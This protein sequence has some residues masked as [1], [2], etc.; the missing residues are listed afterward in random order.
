MRGTSEKCRLPTIRIWQSTPLTAPP[1]R[2]HPAHPRA[3]APATSP[4]SAA[5]LNTPHSALVA[6]ADTP[7]P[8]TTGIFIKAKP[9]GLH[10][11]PYQVLEDGIQGPVGL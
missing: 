1:Q 7:Q 10:V 6:G 4:N 8:A 2:L 5:P 11:G 9:H 3:A